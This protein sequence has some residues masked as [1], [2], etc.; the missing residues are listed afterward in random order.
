MNFN[1]NI[2][3]FRDAFESPIIVF[4]C[5]RLDRFSYR[6]VS[7]PGITDTERLVSLLG[8]NPENLKDAEKVYVG[9][10]CLCVEKL[11]M[12][13]RAVLCMKICH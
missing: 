3:A 13:G 1:V 10:L 6:P 7:M 5:L 9:R 2:K 4:C 11:E 8:K 12:S